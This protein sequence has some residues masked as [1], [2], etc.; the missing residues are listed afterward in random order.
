[1]KSKGQAEERQN[2]DPLAVIHLMSKYV[3][4]KCDSKA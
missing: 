1:M 4:T 3:L 2:L